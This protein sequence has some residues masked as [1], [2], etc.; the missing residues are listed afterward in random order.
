[1]FKAKRLKIEG[2]HAYFVMLWEEDADKLGLE[3]GERVK[4]FASSKKE[5]YIVCELETVR[6]TEKECDIR[7]KKGEIGVFHEVFE[8]LRL[9]KDE[10]ICVMP[11]DKPRS[12]EAVKEK[13]HGRKR[14]TEKDF[15]EVIHDIVDNNYSSVETTYFVLACLAHSLS[16][17]EVIALT[18]AMV[19]VGTQL[20][21]RKKKTDIIVDKHCIGGV[22]GN[23]TSILVIPIVAA[24]GL[25]IPKTSSRSITSPSGT[26]DTV[27][28]LM[29]VSLSISEMHSVVEQCGACIAWGGSLDLS[30]ADDLIINVEH[31]LEIDSEGQMIA[32]ILSKKKSV[33]STHVLI[34]IPVGKHTKVSTRSHGLKLKARF[35]KVG[36][37]LGM[38]MKVILSDGSQPIGYGIGP[39]RE[40]EDVMKILRNE[41]GQHE[42]LRE[43]TL[44][45]AGK[46]LEMGELVKP[47]KGAQLADKILSSGLALKKFEEM[48]ELQG[49]YAGPKQAKY[50]ENFLAEK[51][52]RVVEIHNKKVSKLAF[53]LGCPSDAESGLIL[54]KSLGD[55]V[56]KGD[57]LFEMHSN[58]KV[59]IKYG[60]LFAEE[61]EP[62]LVK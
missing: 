40:A 47:G 58:S 34:D 59:K 27:E 49:K 23:R 3:A 62:F 50:S 44:F 11:A 61:K 14:L 9:R 5:Q 55:K 46:I 8:K 18:K 16:D 51:S 22:P 31:P 17:E 48:M 33:G 13:F 38:Q 41:E 42:I 2:S 25:I 1:M 54:H 30:P 37:A 24:A 52:G 19:G 20:D 56:E 15:Q 43:K 21:F 26:A 53:S 6:C 57:V 28:V 32:S 39:A 12:L 60:R 35:E 4:V 7:V 36:K 10:R 45:M 29:N